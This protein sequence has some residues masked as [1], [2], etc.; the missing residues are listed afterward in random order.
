MDPFLL[1]TYRRVFSIVMGEALH[2]TVRDPG[3]ARNSGC[4][5]EQLL[6]RLKGMR[7]HQ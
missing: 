7:G 2:D 3:V 4:L 6:D 5:P 1:N